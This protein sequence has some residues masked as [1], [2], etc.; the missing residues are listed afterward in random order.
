MTK[1]RY[2]G[3]VLGGVKA[4]I[5][6]AV[7]AALPEV[8]VEDDEIVVAVA[9]GVE[10][11]EVGPELCG[12][13]GGILPAV[14]GVFRLAGNAGNTEAELA[15]LEGGL[16]LRGIFEQAHA[17]LI[18]VV[19]FGPALCGLSHLQNFLP[20]VRAELY[21]QP[22]FAVREVLDAG[23]VLAGKAS[24][25]NDLGVEAFN[26]NGLQRSDV[27]GLVAGL[28]DAGVGQQQKH[29][30]LRTFDESRTGSQGNGAGAF[31]TDQRAGHVEA[32]F[33]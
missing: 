33:G 19:A 25:F 2:F 16:L 30:M 27:W 26:S 11:A 7:D 13:N 9:E 32:V 4:E 14:P 28:E 17:D 8:A 1:R 18:A 10:V 22:G 29:S 12:F 20:G 21:Q 6:A 23:H 5:D 15:H 3:D 24:I 31:R